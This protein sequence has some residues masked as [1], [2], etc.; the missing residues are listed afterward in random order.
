MSVYQTRDE[1]KG[2]LVTI[3]EAMCLS[4]VLALNLIHVVNCPREEMQSCHQGREHQ[5]TVI[6]IAAR[7]M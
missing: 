5:V 2:F 1:L 7:V 3:T 4:F 6:F